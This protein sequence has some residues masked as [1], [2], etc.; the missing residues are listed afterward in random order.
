LNLARYDRRSSRLAVAVRAK[1]RKIGQPIVIAITIP[2]MEA[3][4]DCRVAPFVQT[5]GLALVFL[6]AGTDEPLLEIAPAAVYTGHQQLLDRHRRRTRRDGSPLD[7][8]MPG[9]P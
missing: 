1:E 9:M 5:A 8:F 7:C 4:R 6:D 2:V 3:E